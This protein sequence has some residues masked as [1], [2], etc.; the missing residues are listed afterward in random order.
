MQQR[1][2][3][4][5]LVFTSNIALQHV[6]IQVC[7][8]LCVCT[9]TALLH[10]HVK[11]QIFTFCFLFM[12][13]G[14]SKLSECKRGM[15]MTWRSL[16][17]SLWVQW[18]AQGDNRT[19]GISLKQFHWGHFAPYNGLPTLGHP[20]GASNDTPRLSSGT[21]QHA[22]RT[23]T[24]TLNTWCRSKCSFLSQP[25]EWKLSALLSGVEFYSPQNHSRE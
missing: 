12:E 18:W 7:M 3:V 6:H 14:A 22:L 23:W 13:G 1:P 2:S 5:V 25:C 24:N 19:I 17:W 15:I 21:I 11:V 20:N 10:V 16:T 8:F 9:D 4:Y